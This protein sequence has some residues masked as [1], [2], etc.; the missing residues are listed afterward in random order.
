MRVC[1]LACLTPSIARMPSSPG[2]RMSMSMTCGFADR[3]SAIASKPSSAS[4]TS[5]RSSW[6]CTAMRSPALIKG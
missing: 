4:P 1:G 2:I 5:S 3:A 6:D